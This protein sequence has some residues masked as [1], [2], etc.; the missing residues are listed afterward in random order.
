MQT[1]LALQFGVI[2]EVG[3]APNYSLMHPLCHLHVQL[4]NVPMHGV[5]LTFGE[6]HGSCFQMMMT[7][8]T[9]S[10]QHTMPCPARVLR[11]LS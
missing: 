1:E 2:T 6:M 3:A 7:F 5:G 9:R 11:A 10:V 4:L 8:G